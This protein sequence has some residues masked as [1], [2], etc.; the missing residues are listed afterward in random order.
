[1]SWA[2]WDWLLTWLTNHCPS[3]L[4]HCWLGHVTNKTVSEMTYSVLSGTLNSTIPYHTQTFLHHLHH[5][6]FSI[7]DAVQVLPDL[8]DKKED[9]ATLGS[10]Q[11]R[12]TW[13][14]P[15]EL[16][17]HDCLKEGHYPGWLMMHCDTAM[18]QRS[19]LRKKM[20]VDVKRSRFLTNISLYLG[21]NTI[22]CHSG[23]AIGACMRCIECVMFF[24][25]RS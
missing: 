7:P 23:I 16:W 25:S 8:K 15:T 14:G 1:M 24:Q 19:T 20:Q 9:V 4:W 22:Y 18:L 5:F 3:V 2:W 6:S 10:V 17:P 13:P 11:L 12:H 21:N